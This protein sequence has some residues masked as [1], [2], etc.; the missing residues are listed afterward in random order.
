MAPVAVVVVDVSATGAPVT[1]APPPPPATM[2]NELVAAPGL[3]DAL[4]EVTLPRIIQFCMDI[5]VAVVTAV[6]VATRITEQYVTVFVA[7]LLRVRFLLVPDVFGL[8]PFMVTLSAPFSSMRPRPVGIAVADEPVTVTPSADGCMSTEV[9][10]ALPAPVLFSTAGAVSAVLAEILIVM[11]PWW[12][13]PL[14]A[15]KAAPSVL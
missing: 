2:P 3:P 7:L 6:E 11:A 1:V 8:S 10:T 13:P 12:V 14:I 9:Y 15:V 4:P 5:P